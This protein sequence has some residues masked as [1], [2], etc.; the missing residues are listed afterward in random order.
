MTQ[1]SMPYVEQ[2]EKAVPRFTTQAV[3]KIVEV[4]QVLIEEVPIDVPQVQIAE[5]IRQEAKAVMQEVI[6]EVPKAVMKYLEKVVEIS[7]VATQDTSLD[8]GVSTSV[9]SGAGSTYPTLTS[10][11]MPMGTTKVPSPVAAVA[12]PA[13]VAS[14]SSSPGLQTGFAGTSVATAN[15]LNSSGLGRGSHIRASSPASV[16]MRTASPLRPQSSPLSG[17]IP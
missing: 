6:K 5:V 17:A 13:A 14:S 8:T 15:I 9:L 7:Q 11:Q 3:E 1:V 2:V 10:M 16:H 4:P 12:A